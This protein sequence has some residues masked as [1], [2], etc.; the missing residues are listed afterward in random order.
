MTRMSLEIRGLGKRKLSEL[1][2]NAKLR[3]MTTERYV[4]QLID[5]SLQVSREARTKTFRQIMGPSQEFDEAELDQI[6]ERARN[7]H[8]QKMLSQKTR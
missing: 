8:H 1:Q 5:R 6:V 2:S 3:G 7:R 4:K